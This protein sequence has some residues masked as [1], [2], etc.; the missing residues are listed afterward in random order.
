M[1]TDVMW[2]ME[3]LVKLSQRLID[4]LPEG[5]SKRIRWLPNERLVR[6][7]T[8][9][10][11]LDRPAAIKGRT[12]FYNLRHL[13]QVLAIKTLQAEG[14]SL[15]ECQQRLAGRSDQELVDTIGLPADF[16]G[17]LD[18]ESEEEAAPPPPRRFWERPPAEPAV[19]VRPRETFALQGLELAPGVQLVIDSRLYPDLDPA[20]LRRAATDLVE[21]LS[22]A[23]QTTEDTL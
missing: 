2:R 7:Y 21:L 20:R 8:T 1:G 17:R 9:L 13:L 14:L 18:G 23:K 15:Q 16:K 11:L 10:G 4:L 3:E 6:Y 5:D 19:Q 12:A 22:Q